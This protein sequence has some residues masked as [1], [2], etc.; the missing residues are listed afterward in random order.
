MITFPLIGY[1][2]TTSA[3]PVGWDRVWDL[4]VVLPRWAKAGLALLFAA[5][6]A[7]MLTLQSGTQ[8]DVGFERNFAVIGVWL[9][10][11][12]TALHYA[13]R[14]GREPGAGR[15]SYRIALAVFIIGGVVLAAATFL[16]GRDSVFDEK[17]TH[18]RLA[19]QF[20]SAPWYPHLVAANTYH[21]AYIVY[22]D[23]SDRTV[24]VDACT[25]LKPVA[26]QLGRVP[27]LYSVINGHNRFAMSC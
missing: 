26:A 16:L 19:A 11:V 5:T 2:F 24:Q 20:G 23:T 18:D 15:R 4:I 27:D 8:T 25:D 14:Q 9:T 6:T 21:G 10:A 1:L 7:S 12:G 22:L 13:L 17:A 3:R